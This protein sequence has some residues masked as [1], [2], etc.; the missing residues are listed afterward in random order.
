MATKS[1][2]EI[3]RHEADA[4]NAKKQAETKAVEILEAAKAESRKSSGE[5]IEKARQQAR[6][7]TENAEKTAAE[8]LKKAEEEA[9]KRRLEITEASSLLKDEAIKA[10]KDILLG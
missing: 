6:I 10:A 1:V 4:E 2:E 7:I 8:M 9:H 3:L 5:I